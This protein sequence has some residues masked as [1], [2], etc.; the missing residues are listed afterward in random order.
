M[1]SIDVLP[2]VQ[3]VD[4]ARIQEAL[5]R[6]VWATIAK[7]WYMNESG[8]IVNNWPH[9]TARYYLRT[10]RADLAKY[11]AVLAPAAAE[12]FPRVSDAPP[13]ELPVPA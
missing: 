7:S 13:R 10:L 8:R 9:S 4:S 6:S 1:R 11:R 12:V 3:A 5:S 2:E